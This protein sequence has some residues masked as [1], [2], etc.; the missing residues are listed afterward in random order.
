MK[1]DGISYYDLL[2]KENND[3]VNDSGQLQE[4]MGKWDGRR[5]IDALELN[6]NKTVLEIGVGTGDIAHSRS[7]RRI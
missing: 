5:F 7:L 4:Y 3:P 6:K 2:V 1:T